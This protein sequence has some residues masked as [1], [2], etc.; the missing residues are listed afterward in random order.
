[1]IGSSSDIDISVSNIWQ[2]WRLFR[3]GK[4]PSYEIEAFEYN[5]EKN[6]LQLA[7][8]IKMCSYKHGTYH[9]FTVNDS[10]KR[11]IA[12]ASIR[13]RVV[14][15]LLY[16]YLVDIFDNTFVNNVWSCRP[17]KGLLGAIERAQ[18]HMRS[19]RDG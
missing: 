16:E 7:C 8:D 10:K 9:Q 12:V 3:R 19:F 14:H 2:A 4:S 5:L 6:I 17:G 13:D 15:R 11:L 18:N 1:M